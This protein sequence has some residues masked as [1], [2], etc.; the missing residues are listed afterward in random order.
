MCIFRWRMRCV[1]VRRLSDADAAASLCCLSIACCCLMRCRPSS[2]SSFPLLSKGKI[3]ESSSSFTTCK[4]KKGKL[5]L[6]R[7][8][9]ENTRMKKKAC[10][11]IPLMSSLFFHFI[12]RRRG[13]GRNNDFLHINVCSPPLGGTTFFSRK[14]DKFWR[15]KVWNVFAETCPKAH[16]KFNESVFHWFLL[17]CG[18]PPLSESSRPSKKYY[19]A[20]AYVHLVYGKTTEATA[21]NS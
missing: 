8:R 9:R 13:R 15:K 2:S 3:S 19:C 12:Y 10:L 14:F 20:R 6:Q 7:R 21:G 16:F 11:G 1:R 18:A 4:R 5:S 17:F